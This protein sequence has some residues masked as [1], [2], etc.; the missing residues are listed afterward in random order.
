MLK[1]K[2]SNDGIEHPTVFIY[3]SLFIY[4]KYTQKIICGSKKKKKQL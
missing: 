2:H 3:I 1:L 4:R